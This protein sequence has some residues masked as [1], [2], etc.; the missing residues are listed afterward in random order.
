MLVNSL[1]D[2]GVPLFMVL[3]QHLEGAKRYPKV[4]SEL[5][6]VRELGGSDFGLVLQVV[7]PFT[8]IS[9]TLL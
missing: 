8:I 7:V 1:L 3:H 2:H 4:S 9:Q 6:G 5:L